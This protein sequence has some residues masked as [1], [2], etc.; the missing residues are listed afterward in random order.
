M[1]DIA[2]DNGADIREPSVK[3]VTLIEITG[4]IVVIGQVFALLLTLFNPVP[5]WLLLTFVFLSSYGISAVILAGK[6]TNHFIK[7]FNRNLEV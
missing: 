7:A 5:Q 1:C 6:F 2:E 4:I 3:S